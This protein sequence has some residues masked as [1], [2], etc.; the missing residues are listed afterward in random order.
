M[1]L[2]QIIALWLA[3]TV[4][5]TVAFPLVFSVAGRLK[6]RGYAISRVV[7]LVL[8]TFPAWILSSAR[9]LPFGTVSVGLSLLALAAFSWRAAGRNRKELIAFFREKKIL[10]LTIE[11]LFLLFFILFLLF[12]ALN[13]NIDPDSER[14]MDYALL[15][16]IEKTAYFPPLTPGWRGRR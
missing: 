6:D 7:G 2:L 8:I 3:S 1:I 13:P 5:G 4:V 11:G 16:G 12:V 14:F 15:N 10:L 9:I